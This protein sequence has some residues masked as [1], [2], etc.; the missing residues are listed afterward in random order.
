MPRTNKKS[1]L[2]RAI[3]L[4]LQEK[5]E[6]MRSAEVEQSL[7]GEY[8]AEKNKIKHRV[9]VLHFD[10]LLSAKNKTCEC[11]G[12]SFKIWKINEQGKAAL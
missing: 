1:G 11:C 4:V 6:G 5:P 3:L 8:S 7:A 10:G 2:S 12:Y 9:A